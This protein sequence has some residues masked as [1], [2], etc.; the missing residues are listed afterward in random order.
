MRDWPEKNA[1]SKNTHASNRVIQHMM[2]LY[3]LVVE[4]LKCRLERTLRAFQSYFKN[5]HV[6]GRCSVVS[7][8]LKDLLIEC[9]TSFKPCWKRKIHWC[10][11]NKIYS[12]SGLHFGGWF[13]KFADER[14]SEMNMEDLYGSIFL[15]SIMLPKT[16]KSQGVEMSPSIKQTS[17]DFVPQLQ[18]IRNP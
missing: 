12:W 4:V 7:K 1:A 15:L 8:V 3:S 16:D 17:T 11:M 9:K 14:S 6:G 5:A 18:Y 2:D 13:F 10:N